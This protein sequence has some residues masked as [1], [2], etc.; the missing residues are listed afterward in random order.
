MQPNAAPAETPEEPEKVDKAEKTSHEVVVAELGAS[1]RTDKVATP[2][3]T[4]EEIEEASSAMGDF[5]LKCAAWSTLCVY[6]LWGI[7]S[8][9][10]KDK[11][12]AGDSAFAGILLATIVAFCFISNIGYLAWFDKSK[13]KVRSAVLLVATVLLGIGAV[14]AN[15][16]VAF[17]M[18]LIVIPI[19]L[20][21]IGVVMNARR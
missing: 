5:V 11:L 3:A 15:G 9:K 4:P 10:D 7:V 14:Y 13:G 2:A 1:K 6:L 17:N 8:F 16:L 20:Q 19:V 12:F 18:P 21:L